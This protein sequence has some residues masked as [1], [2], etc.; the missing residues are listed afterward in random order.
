MLT[1][2]DNLEV[3][4]ITNVMKLYVY[5][6]VKLL[7]YSNNI[8]KV[9]T[10]LLMAECIIIVNQGLTNR[11]QKTNFLFGCDSESHPVSSI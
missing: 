9:N 3:H 4:F 5:N 7:Y 6:V 8:F 2:L 1:G 11:V 10:V